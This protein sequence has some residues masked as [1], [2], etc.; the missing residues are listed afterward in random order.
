MDHHVVAIDGEAVAAGSDGRAGGPQEVGVSA[1]VDVPRG[2]DSVVGCEMRPPVI[3]VRSQDVT[4]LFETLLSQRLQDQGRPV[5]RQSFVSTGKNSGSKPSTSTLM[6]SARRP[7]STL[8][9]VV[10][11]IAGPVPSS[12]ALA[13]GGVLRDRHPRGS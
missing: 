10:N 7:P 3:T 12:S 6:M 13:A 1:H 4:D 11:S 2:Q 5:T 9:M 8:S